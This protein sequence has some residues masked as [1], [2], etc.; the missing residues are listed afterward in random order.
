MWRSVWGSTDMFPGPG[1]RGGAAK[2]GLP[3]AMITSPRC[4]SGRQSFPYTETKPADLELIVHYPPDWKETDKRP[5][6][7]FF[8]GGGWTGGKS[9]LCAPQANH[10]AGCGMVAVR[11]DYLFFPG[12]QSVNTPT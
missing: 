9:G 1:T 8:F 3:R 11:A 6:I 5:A 10:L 2:R 12:L 4:G 7:V